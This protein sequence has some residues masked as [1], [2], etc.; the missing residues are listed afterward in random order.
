MGTV[1]TQQSLREHPAQRRDKA[2]G[3]DIHVREP[4]DDIERTVRVDGRKDEVTGQCRLNGD[5][6]RLR[7][8]N[9]AHHDAIRVVAQDRTQATGECQTLLLV[10]GDL[11]HAWQLVLDG[12]FDGDDLV[13]AVVDF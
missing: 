3:I 2:V 7:I 8:A 12:V 1:E 5:L 10:D 13:V 9:L 4:A 11:Q 6:R